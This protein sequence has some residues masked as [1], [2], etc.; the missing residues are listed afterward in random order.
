M[1][2]TIAMFVWGF[3]CLT[4]AT[5]VDAHAKKKHYNPPSQGDTTESAPVGVPE[6]LDK[7]R[8]AIQGNNNSEVLKWK[9][10]TP[11]Q[12]HDRALIVGKFVKVLLDRQSHLQFEV[13]L[14]NGS[15]D[16]VSEHI[17]IIYNKEFGEIPAIPA[18]ASIAACGDYI[19]A[20]AQSGPYPPSP[21]GAI[22]HWVHASNNPQKHANGYVMVNGKVFGYAGDANKNR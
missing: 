18:G 9:T 7:D 11:N 3:V 2:K 6:C 20:S 14:S 15:S 5:S 19:T 16:G 8:R 13:D 10:Q 17:E 12:Y 4:L 22:I 1:Q 21:M